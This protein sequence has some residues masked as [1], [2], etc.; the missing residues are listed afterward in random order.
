MDLGISGKRA[1]VAAASQ[2][3]GL[4][5]RRGARRGGR[6]GRDLR[7]LPG[8]DRSRRRRH[9]AAPS[10]SSPTCPPK[11][12]RAQFVRDARDALG[13]VDILVANGGGPPPGD[14]R[15]STDLALVQPGVRAELPR[16]RRDVPRGGARDAGAGVG[17]GARDHVDLGPPADPRPD[18]LQHRARRRHRLPQDARPRGRGRRRHRELASSPGSHDTERIR[19]AP[20]ATRRGDGDPAGGS[21]TRRTSG[22]SPP[23]C[24]RSRP[25]FVTGAAIHVDGGAY[26]GLQ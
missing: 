19:S 2:G 10:R 16:R 1:A 25:K 5:H 23:S 7:P 3:L 8:Q 12:V 6:A 17:A 22:G 24:A 20:A 14:L 26:Q 21:A 18:P 13:G 4:R 15:D 11:P 9:P